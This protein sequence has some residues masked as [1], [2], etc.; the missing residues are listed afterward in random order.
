MCLDVYYVHSLHFTR[1]IKLRFAAHVHRR[2]CRIYPSS[3]RKE[4]VSD[5]LQ[6]WLS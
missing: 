2:P 1:L 5:E 6:L 4:N 3:T